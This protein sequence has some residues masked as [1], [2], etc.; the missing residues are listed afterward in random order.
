MKQIILIVLC[1]WMS[2]VASAHNFLAGKLDT[3]IQTASLLKTSEVGLVVYDLTDNKELYS[4]QA[5]KLYR[6][7]SIEKVITAVTALATLGNDYQFQTRLAYSGTLNGGVLDGDLYVIGGFDPEFMEQDMKRLTQA[8]SEA[9][10]TSLNGRLIGD[11]SLMDSIYW[12]T[13]WVWDDTPEPF[14]PYLSPL[15][16]NR[17]CMSITVTPSEKGDTGIVKILPESDFYH[18]DNRSVSHI[19]SAG[20]LSISRNWL[21]NGNTIQITGNVSSTR[22]RLLNVFD[23]KS[24]FME[25]FCY[26]LLQEG[27]AVNRDSIGYAEAPEDASEIYTFRRPLEWVLKRALKKSDNLSAEALF[28]LLGTANGKATSGLGFED[29]QRVI[30]RFMRQSLG[31]RPGNYKIVDGSGVSVYNYVSPKLIL[32]YLNYAYR[33]PDIFHPFYE[34]LPVAGVDGT[35]RYRMSRGKTFRN[36]HAKTGTVT[37]VC[38]L[39]GYVTAANG[40]KL[41]F[42]IINQN[43]LKA[44][45]ARKFQDDVCTLLSEMD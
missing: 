40:H 37:G 29:S 5:D 17:G 28:R 30:Y 26:Q 44:R 21:E 33:H 8:V 1:G 38:S 39:A 18:V 45:M 2:V 31:Y 41:S 23:S 3:L 35:L 7:A 12:G 15:M 11:V 4:Y 9:G 25:T 36:V 6:P 22:G 24:F 42:V 32:A 13:G 16:L 10:I 19:P 43:V 14:Q 27:I 34:G 20:S